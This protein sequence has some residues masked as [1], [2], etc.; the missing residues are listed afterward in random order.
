VSI[1]RAGPK[2][3]IG[4]VGLGEIGQPMAMRV[5]EAGYPTRV[6]NRNAARTAPFGDRGIEIAASPAA[7]ARGCDVVLVCVTDGAAVEQVVFGRDG[8]A[9]G[10]RPGQLLIDLSTIHPHEVRAMAER[11][12]GQVGMAWVDAPVSGGPAGARAGTLAAMV[13][14]AAADVERA[15]PVLTSFAGK[16]THMGPVG[17]GTA[18]KACNQMI[19]FCTAAVI[20]ETLSFAARFGL[21]P[22]LLPD[23]LAGG[24]A[25]SSVLRHLGPALVDGTYTGDGAMGVKDINIALDLGR[26]TGSPMPLTGLVASMF[27]LVVS[28]GFTTGG[29]GTPMRLYAQGPLTRTATEASSLP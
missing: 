15:R 5:I 9:A 25:D 21:D 8:V 1:D 2:E 22:A 20:A 19:G 6:W 12:R 7:L 17:C 3:R 23:A 14:G 27:Q 4:F 24:F 28:Q 16:V 18:T 10:G 26:R 29:L 13:G 11:L